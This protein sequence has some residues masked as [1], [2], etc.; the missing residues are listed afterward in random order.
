MS[1]SL[2]T[3][4][5]EIFDGGGNCLNCHGAGGV[6]TSL[7]P[8]LMRG[9]QW[10]HIDGSYAQIAT[11]VNTGVPKPK[12]FPAPMPPKGGAALSP[13]QVCAVAAYVYSLS[14]AQSASK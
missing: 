3:Q 6:G 4:G 9:H 14:H 2:V 7:A 13:G 10:I 8:D 11:L 5:A 12:E 1:A